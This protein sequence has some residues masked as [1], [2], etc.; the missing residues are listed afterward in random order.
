MRPKRAVEIFGREAFKGPP[1]VFTQLPV[2]FDALL[3][4]SFHLDDGMPGG[5]SM[6]EV[7]GPIAAD[8]CLFGDSRPGPP[9]PV[10]VTDRS[11]FGSVNSHPSI[12]AF[13]C[14]R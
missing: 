1:D 3:P 2:E 10:V 9:L 12:D 6:P 8:P 5:E 14:N 11:P 13:D 4:I 7:V